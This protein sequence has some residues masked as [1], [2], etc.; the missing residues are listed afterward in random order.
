MLMKKAL[1]F[2]FVL[3]IIL[4]PVAFTPEPV[5]AQGFL[6]RIVPACNENLVNGNFAD[7]CNICHIVQLI[8]NA[9]SF[10][11]TISVMIATLMF[12]YAGFLY[13][14]AGGSPEKIKSATKIFT[15]VFIGLVFVLGAFLIVDTIMKTFYNENTSFG[16]WN[17]IE[18]PTPQAPRSVSKPSSNDSSVVSTSESSKSGTDGLR[19]GESTYGVDIDGVYEQRSDGTKIYS[20][21]TIVRPEN[22]SNSSSNSGNGF[23]AGAYREYG[24]DEITFGVDANGSYKVIGEYPDGAPVR[25][26]TDKAYNRKQDEHQN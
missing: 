11:I 12:V 24:D 20:D 26:Y 10:L 23:A 5:S 16:P 4:I 3:A 19:E 9:L 14:T 2:F 7:R 22:T 17:E 13:L 21:G 25:V 1:I 15:N 8:Q 18:C 6:D